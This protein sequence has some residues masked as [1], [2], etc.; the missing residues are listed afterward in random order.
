M[1][2]GCLMRGHGLVPLLPADEPVVVPIHGLEVRL[3]PCCRCRCCCFS[4]R[5]LS[6][7]CCLPRMRCGMWRSLL[8][9]GVPLGR[10]RTCAAWKMTSWRYLR[11]AEHASWWNSPRRGYTT[12]PAVSHRHWR[13][14]PWRHRTHTWATGATRHRTRRARSARSAR[15]A[16]PTR[17]GNGRA[18]GLHGW[19]LG[20]PRHSRCWRHLHHGVPGSS[21]LLFDLRKDF[22]GLANQIFELLRIVV[23]RC[24][25]AFWLNLLQLLQ[26]S[27]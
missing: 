19:A 10:R 15:T 12:W 4:P 9:V 21:L 22:C 8:V 1:C 26:N 23:P 24:F 11:V 6:G 18:V 13:P 17:H 27:L 3:C 14:L 16:R 7:R 25:R 2:C 5:R 20:T